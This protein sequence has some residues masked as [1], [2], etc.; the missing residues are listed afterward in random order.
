MTQQTKRRN[1]VTENFDAEQIYAPTQ[2]LDIVK[3]NA[4]AK[5]DETVEV[6]FKLGID[7]RKSDQMVRGTVSLPKGT[8]KETR[9]AGSTS[10]QP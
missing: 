10:M 7:P 4:T 9:V 1:A 8:G 5:F 6:A 2:A 3:R